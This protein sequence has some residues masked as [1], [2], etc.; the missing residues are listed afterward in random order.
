[1][2][3]DTRETRIPIVEEQARVG[4]RVVESD[5]VTVRTSVDE[6]ME[7]VTADLAKDEVGIERVPIGREVADEPQV[8]WEGEV[9]V[10]PV[11][12]EK[13]VIQKR[14]MLV[15]ELHIRRHRQ[16]ETAEVPVT[17]K[18]TVVS[19]QRQAAQHGNEGS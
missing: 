18:R 13:L 6:H 14:R 8:R 15:E 2:S 1:M 10:I 16:L 9:L 11:V 3:D 12:E 4:K 5:V 19:V 17:L 7:R